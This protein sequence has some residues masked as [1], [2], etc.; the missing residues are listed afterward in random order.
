MSILLLH[1]LVFYDYSKKERYLCMKTL[2][3]NKTK[4]FWFFSKTIRSSCFAH[5]YYN[6][7]CMC[8]DWWKE[9]LSCLSLIKLRG[10]GLVCFILD[11]N[12]VWFFFLL[13]QSF[14]N[15]YTSWRISFWN[16][17]KAKK[18]KTAAAQT[19]FSFLL[20][21]YLWG[22]VEVFV[23]QMSTLDENQL[24]WEFKDGGKELFISQHPLN[25]WQKQR[26][27]SVS[28]STYFFTRSVII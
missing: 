14:Y 16:L 9:N 18:E 8:A 28:V 11:P 21:M 17:N 15:E 25:K 10:G 22:E 23:F 19:L 24:V 2:Y 3:I 12:R 4:S 20:K 1:A 13:P 27:W 5:L 26:W 6:G 7:V